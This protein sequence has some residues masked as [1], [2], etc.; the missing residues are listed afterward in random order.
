MELRCFPALQH[1]P[2]KGAAWSSC[3]ARR[4]HQTCGLQQSPAR[5]CGCCIPLPRARASSIPVEA[6]GSCH[7]PSFLP[8]AHPAAAFGSFWGVLGRTLWLLR[9]AG[10]AG[11]RCQPFV[12]FPAVGYAELKLLLIP[13]ASPG[14]C[15]RP[16]PEA[17]SLPWRAGWGSCSC[18]SSRCQVW[19]EFVAC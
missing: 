7:L 18:F 3:S 6:A 10:R 17:D 5:S 2:S 19:K 13:A 14:V 1:P 16:V 11:S 15:L 9:P 12:C 8:S 4:C